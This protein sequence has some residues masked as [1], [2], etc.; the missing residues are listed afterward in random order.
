MIC[1]ECDRPITGEFIPT[2]KGILHPE[3]A[4]E[5]Y[6]AGTDAYRERIERE[7]G[8]LRLESPHDPR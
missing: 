2:P 8:Q 7:Y 5:E 1:P 4:P 6:R 3:C